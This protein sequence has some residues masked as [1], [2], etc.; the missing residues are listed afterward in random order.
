MTVDFA[1]P[2][3]TSDGGLLLL[4]QTETK[5]N[6]LSRLA[7]C[8]RDARDPTRVQHSVAEL[9]SQRVFGLALGYE[10][11]NDHDRL[12]HDPLLGA[13]AGKTDQRAS[14]AGK[15]TLNR[16]E[17]STE[18][19]TRYKKISCDTAAIDRLLVDVFQEAHSVAPA[20]IVL[21]LDST[22]LPLYGHQEQRFFHGFGALQ[23]RP[24]SVRQN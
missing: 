8:F 17:L 6:L 13:M 23:N 24:V 11:L 2:T 9:L 20:Q 22:D 21:D 15:S 12:S 18:E 19:V 14:L 5:L 1:G 7:L 10:D 4:K 3:V 16:L